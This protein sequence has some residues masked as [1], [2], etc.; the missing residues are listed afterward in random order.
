M[1]GQAFLGAQVRMNTFIHLAVSSHRQG[2]FKRSSQ[3]QVSSAHLSWAQVHPTLDPRL[4]PPLPTLKTCLVVFLG[5]SLCA[6]VS[7]M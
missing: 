2:G 3:P 4:H 7:H 5:I 1:G 6:F